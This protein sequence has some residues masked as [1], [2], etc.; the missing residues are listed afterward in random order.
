MDDLPGHVLRNGLS[1]GNAE[2][3]CPGRFGVPPG[4]PFKCPN[5]VFSLI[6]LSDANM[7]E[8]RFVVKY[9]EV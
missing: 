6:S 3:D 2:V 1:D 8:Y 9:V 7:F 5:G 4:S